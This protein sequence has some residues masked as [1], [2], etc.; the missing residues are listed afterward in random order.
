ML[1]A[2]IAALSLAGTTSVPRKP[3]LAPVVG[4]RS[5][6]AYSGTP[7]T[8]IPA[9]PTTSNY[10]IS[11]TDLD[12]VGAGDTTTYIEATVAGSPATF[13]YIDCLVDFGTATVAS[14]ADVT[15]WLAGSGH[16]VVF[17]WNGSTWIHASSKAVG[18][19]S[20]MWQTHT[21]NFNASGNNRYYLVR[22]AHYTIFGTP[23]DPNWVYYRAGD[24]RI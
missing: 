14:T 9:S 20:L 1:L 17:A 16:L 18:A 5:G 15:Y 19:S 11:T 10:W 23:P 2:T 7:V 3:V 13:S 22:V 12:D 24:I 6:F 21:T 4:Y 8:A